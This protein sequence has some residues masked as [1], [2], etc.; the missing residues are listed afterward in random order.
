MPNISLKKLLVKIIKQTSPIGSVQMFA[1]DNPPNGW[2]LCDGRSLLIA[3]YPKLANALYSQDLQTYIYGAADSSHF[4]LP[5]FRGRV[6]VGAGTGTVTDATSH[7]LG[8]SNGTET[9]TLTA[10]QS[11]QRALTISGGEHTHQL[12]IASSKITNTGSKGA[13]RPVGYASSGTHGYTSSSVGHTHTVAAANA[14]EAHNN[15]QPYLVIN[16]IIFTG[17]TS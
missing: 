3:D 6:P 1:G 8:D 4:N 11:G 16:Y 7:T 14:T 12:N 15:M 17:K 2:L 5:D 9:V 13:D 10:N